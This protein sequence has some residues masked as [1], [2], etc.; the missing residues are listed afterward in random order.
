MKL[1]SKIGFGFGFILFLTLMLGI[2]SIYSMNNARSNSRELKIVNVN[3]LKISKV[4][5]DSMQNLMLDMR[6]YGFTRDKKD[7]EKG[8]ANLKEL[9]NHISEAYKTINSEEK[10]NF[11]E[12]D[13]NIIESELEAYENLMTKSKIIV[14]E[15]MPKI[16][17][18]L[19]SVTVDFYKNA[20]AYLQSQELKLQSIL[21]ESQNETLRE[22]IIDRNKKKDIINHVIDLVGEARVLNLKGQLYKDFS[23]IEKSIEYFENIEKIVSDLKDVSKM[24]A[25]IQQL[26]MI[27]QSSK[28]YKK[29]MKEFFDAFIALN[30]LSVERGEIGENISKVCTSMATEALNSTVN[31]AEKTN[32]NS[33]TSMKTL[34]VVILLSIV[35]GIT[36]AI[37]LT[38]SI[39]KP[40]VRVVDEL[41]N[42]S[43]QVFNASEQLSL[44]S[45]ELA[46]SSSE[47]ASSIEETSSTLDET[48]SMVKQNTENTK[49]ASELTQK[50]REF[51]SEGNEQMKVMMEAM[52]DIQNSSNE[53]AK[54]IKVIDDIAFQTNMLALNA[55][56]EAARA[57]EAGMGFAVVAEEVRILAQRS[58]QAAKDTSEM[59]ENSITKSEKGVNIAEKV[60]KFLENIH[61]QSEKINEIVKEIST[62][63]QEQ[64][65]GVIQ[66]SKAVSQMEQVTQSIASN[67]EESAAASEELNAQAENMKQ[68]VGDLNYFVYA[69]H[70]RRNPLK[71]EDKIYH[72]KE[73]SKEIEKH[74]RNA[75]NV[76]SLEDD[77]LDF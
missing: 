72:S 35:F 73:K 12:V 21:K 7:Y 44:A 28:G 20:N 26:D 59:I 6:T 43:E 10:L 23:S 49:K 22:E 66:I 3:Q 30:N 29:S 61:G 36:T 13:I 8:V 1:S 42:G 60:A 48:S 67:A 51:A 58:T 47:Q 65:Q 56:V 37:I 53:I 54:I 57:G 9:R 14:E 69:T 32:S 33:D 11:L 63:S 64:T 71:K 38:K 5:E 74:S 34:Y 25:N 70:H 15:S 68:I 2:I 16:E 62:A 50:A 52:S 39:V 45:Q 31:L 76:I 18:D 40:I 17:G 4:L 19:I 24:P 27:L 75:E 55:A 41:A 46:D 77:P